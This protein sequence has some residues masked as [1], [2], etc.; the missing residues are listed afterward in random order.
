MSSLTESGMEL[1]A[2]RVQRAESDRVVAH[3]HKLDCQEF[4]CV[5][6]FNSVLRTR[7][8]KAHAKAVSRWRVLD[9]EPR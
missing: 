6:M 3:V 7:A 1:V 9:F 4:R 8:R 5:P 2:N